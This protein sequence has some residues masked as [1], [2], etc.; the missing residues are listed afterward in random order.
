MNITAALEQIDYISDPLRAEQP[1]SPAPVG[2]TA[3][4]APLPPYTAVIDGHRLREL[5]HQRGLSQ[6]SLAIR[7]R[8]G[9]RTLA[10]LERRERPHCRTRTL[11][12]LAA[13]LEESPHAIALAIRAR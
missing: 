5:R 13:A 10:R 6:E 11:A 2:I 3:A 7:A 8:V 4:P 1:D 12:R 9:L